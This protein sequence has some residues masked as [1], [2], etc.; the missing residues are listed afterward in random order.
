[1]DKARLKK[2]FDEY[3]AINSVIRAHRVSTSYKLSIP[4]TNSFFFFII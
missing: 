1:M 3:N 2:L 4:E